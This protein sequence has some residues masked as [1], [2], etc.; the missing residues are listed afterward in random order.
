MV[1]A[2][3]QVKKNSM[4]FMELLSCGIL[5]WLIME[6]AFYA[7]G[8]VSNFNG[9][10]ISAAYVGL[11]NFNF[12]ISGLL[13]F[14]NTFIATALSVALVWT[15]VNALGLVKRKRDVIVLVIGTCYS[16]LL[17]VLMLFVL[18]ARRHLMVWAI[19]A[20]KFVFT[21]ATVTVV[22]VSFLLCMTCLSNGRA[23]VGE[24][25]DR[26]DQ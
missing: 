9:L 22:D 19:F 6:Y 10:H 4:S 26:K 5:I 12:I 13:L 17:V 8:H 24:E 16:F 15:G 2:T 25:Q 11:D 18:F 23:S 7:S 21:A 20:P 14:F 3:Q 1:I